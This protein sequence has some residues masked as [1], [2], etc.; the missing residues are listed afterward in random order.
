MPSITF[1]TPPTAVEGQAPASGAVTFGEPPPSKG[2]F[3]YIDDAVRA[4]AQGATFGYA[5][6]LAAKA[7]SL[8]GNKTY[9]QNLAEE[10]Q[11]N[12]QIPAAIKYPGEIAGAVGGAIAS[13][14]VVAPVAAATGIARLPGIARSILAGVTGGALFGSGEA[15]PGGRLA[16]AVTGG[17]IG[18]VAG[19]VLHPVIQGVGA[20]VNAVRS[21]AANVATDLGRA[22]ERDQLSPAEFLARAQDLNQ[23]RP[24]VATLADAGGENVKGLLERVAQTPG[25]GRTIAVP[26][27]TERQQ[28]QLARL[29]M[30]LGSLTGSRRTAIQATEETMAQRAKDASPL[31]DTA[32]NFNATTSPEIT[33][34]WQDVTSTG[35]GEQIINS[36]AFRRTLQTEYGI[37]DP[38]QAP[39]MV[40]IDAFKKAADDLVSSAR[41]GG[42]ANKARVIGGMKDKLL[43]V[44]DTANPAYAQARSAWEGPSK[45][46]E[47][48]QDGSGIMSANLSGEQ[49]SAQLGKM[50]DSQREGYVTGAVS[51]IL[52][53]M[54]SDPAKLVDQTKYLRSPEMRDKVAA[55]MPDEQAAADWLKRL[56][57]EVAASEL[58]ARTLGNSATAR[59]L[60]ERQDADGIMGDLISSAFQ[61]RPPVGMLTQFLQKGGSAIRDTMRSRA[62]NRLASVLT[63]PS[64]IND[65]LLAQSLAARGAP[66]SM[67]ST[68]APTNALNALNP[69][70]RALSSI[71]ARASDEQK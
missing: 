55:L 27:T 53:K 8:I 66:P 71:S 61:G 69:Y 31:Y 59:R 54:R 70:P 22:L 47:A 37:R 11:R 5:D 52:R 51:A 18:G 50:T 3:G 19:G 15:E 48:I 40:Q 46:L 14:P 4:V 1:D 65:A 43:E 17:A 2:A 16:G 49:L 29:S 25:A 42:A 63:D 32:L 33:R 58:S 39:L 62:D 6:E 35:F 68:T 41:S 34:A 23:T 26:A 10:Q 36:N 60:A 13:A 30:D 38:S 7:N 9:E 20:A 12:A 67:L 45:Y 56:D 57:F 21:P 64:A 28:Q 44:V 24:G